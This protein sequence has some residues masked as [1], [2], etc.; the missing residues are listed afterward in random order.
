MLREKT[1][2][3]AGW[4]YCKVSCNDRNDEGIIANTTEGTIDSDGDVKAGGCFS[5]TNTVSILGK[6]TVSISVLQI[7]DYVRVGQDQYSQVYSF[8]HIDHEAETDF[9]QIRTNGSNVPLELT[10]DHLVSVAGTYVRGSDVRVGDMLGDHM[11]VRVDLVH[12]RG[13]YAPV[14]FA[15]TLIV[16]GVLV[17]SYVAT[18]DLLSPF[19]QHWVSHNILSLHRM[20]WSIHADLCVRE[21]YSD[22]ISNFIYSAVRVA[23]VVNT[24]CTW[25]HV[26]FW[27]LSLPPIL[28]IYFFQ[29]V[30]LVPLLSIVF[31]I[32]SRYFLQKRKRTCN[33]EF[34]C[35]KLLYIHQGQKFSETIQTRP[36]HGATAE[37][38]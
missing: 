16:S 26:A 22:G 15:G 30:L 35:Q 2:T 37:V 14:T 24:T 23:K 31:W 5:S 32:A 18:F 6:G 3:V 29:K 8:S 21:T 38:E 10:P 34:V 20:V 27:I 13:V 1:G 25:I 36:E 12:R 19:M 11:V 28:L 9:L 33:N 4:K 7:G 17:S